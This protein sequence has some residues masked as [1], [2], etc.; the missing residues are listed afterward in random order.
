MSSSLLSISSNRNLKRN[1]KKKVEFG[2]NLFQD[3]KSEDM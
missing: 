1:N 2:R 3:G